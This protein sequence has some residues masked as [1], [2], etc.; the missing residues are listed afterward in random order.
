[1]NFNA[2]ILLFG[3]YAAL[4]GSDALLVPFPKFSGILNFIGS[5]NDPIKINSN[6]SLKELYSY[7]KKSDFKKH[8]SLDQFKDD[9]DAGLF[10]DSNIPEGYGVGS[11]GALVA[12]LFKKYAFGSSSDD[13][14]VLKSRLSSLESFYHG[15][16]SGL[17]PLVS[18]LNRSVILSNNDLIIKDVDYTNFNPFLIDTGKTRS[19][20]ELVK[21]FS[22]KCKDTLYLNLIKTEL[23]K[24][25]R[26]IISAIINGNTNEFFPLLRMISSFQLEHFKEMMLPEF[27][28]LWRVGL[29]SDDFYLKLNGAGGG[30]FILG[31]C[32]DTEVF[33]RIIKDEGLKVFQI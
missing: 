15:S 27:D 21:Q 12:A 25:N 9:I 29:K 17:D 33:S 1:M 28:N 8:F 2:K 13:L 24:Y 4:H 11:S 6:E 5:D 7:L 10:F 23:V 3:E 16:S 31:F 30:G 22:V 20:A 26:E 32:K 14:S 18:Y 19:T